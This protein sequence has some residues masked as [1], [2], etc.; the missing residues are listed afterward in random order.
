MVIHR[1]EQ[2]FDQVLCLTLESFVR[3]AAAQGIQ[4][5]PVFIG[6]VEQF[7]S[8]HT[9]VQVTQGGC[10]T[11]LGCRSCLRCGRFRRQRFAERAFGLQHRVPGRRAALAQPY[12]PRVTEPRERALS[13]AYKGLF[14]GIQG[15]RR[16]W[17]LY[18]QHR[19]TVG[20]HI[21]AGIVAMRSLG[22]RNVLLTLYNMPYGH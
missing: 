20:M 17:L 7:G 22:K 18:Y 6:T 11:L 19:H 5:L 13:N 8:G 15:K 3:E 14:L 1:S 21:H 2:C 16:L 9:H 12:I 10:E 4:S